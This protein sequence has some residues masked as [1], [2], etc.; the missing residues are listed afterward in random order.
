MSGLTTHL[1]QVIES[2]DNNCLYDALTA[3]LSAEEKEGSGVE[4]GQDL[5][6]VIIESIH[7]NAALADRVFTSADILRQKCAG[8]LCVWGREYNFVREDRRKEEE[9][10][11]KKDGT[12]EHVSDKGGNETDYFNIGIINEEGEFVKKEEIEQ[13]RG[14]GRIYS[15]RFVEDEKGIVSS[16]IALDQDGN[17]VKGFFLENR[18]KSIPEGEYSLIKSKDRRGANANTLTYPD[19]YV[20]FNSQVAMG[21][22]ITIHNG[23]FYDQSQGCLLPGKSFGKSK[24]GQKGVTSNNAGTLRTFNS[25]TKREELEVFI[26]GRDPEVAKERLKNLVLHIFKVIPDKA[27]TSDK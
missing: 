7:K 19:N 16:L 13:K 2:H 17:E 27:T 18:D 24:L 20:L 4:T 21:R 15:L 5:R 8:A 23:N 1:G 10:V 9:G 6:G 25:D 12:F 14:E 11:E 22:G 3:Q 26:R